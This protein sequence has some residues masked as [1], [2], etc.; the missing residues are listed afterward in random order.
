MSAE[1]PPPGD[2]KGITIVR[3]GRRLWVNLTYR[4]ESK[5]L[6]RSDLSVGLDMGVS[7]R[8]ALSTGESVGRR[9]KANS[10]IVLAQ[11]RLSR[12]RKGSRRWR[13]RRSILSNSQDRER[14]RNR[15]E[16]HRVTTDLV[17]R[18]GLIAIEDL[19]IKNMSRSAKGTV[20]QPGRNVRQKTG[21]NR[22]IAEQSWGYCGRS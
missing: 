11:K 1:L 20:E 13:E 4:V 5:P 16:C 3:R 12:C 18:F 9:D 2:L 21:L 7:D 22:S 8:I 10:R 6:S 15:N 19:A 14:I 17:R